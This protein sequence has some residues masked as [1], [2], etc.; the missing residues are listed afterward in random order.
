[1]FLPSLVGYLDECVSKWSKL[2]IEYIFCLLGL[3]F[4]LVSVIQYLNICFSCLW[5]KVADMKKNSMCHLF[6]LTAHSDT[7]IAWSKGEKIS[8]S[9]HQLGITQCMKN[10][11]KCLCCCCLIL[12]LKYSNVSFHDCH[13]RWCKDHKLHFFL[14]LCVTCEVFYTLASLTSL[15]AFTT[16]NS[17]LNYLSVAAYWQLVQPPGWRSLLLFGSRLLSAWFPQPPNLGWR[18]EGHQIELRGDNDG[19]CDSGLCGYLE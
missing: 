4:F 5:E 16:L 17:K 11:E 14:C 3:F 18:I 9:C 7:L 1:M 6:L 2:Y 13:L 8:S 19:V 15:L 10:F 12:L